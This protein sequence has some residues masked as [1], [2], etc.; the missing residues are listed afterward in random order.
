MSRLNR[1]LKECYRF[2]GAIPTSFSRAFPDPLPPTGIP[3]P[4]TSRSA[5][6]AA[7]KRTCATTP[8]AMR[9]V[10]AVSTP[11]PTPTR[12]GEHGAERNSSP[13]GNGVKPDECDRR[14]ADRDRGRGA[15]RQQRPRGAREQRLEGALHGAAEEQLLD[16]RREEH[17]G[18]DRDGELIGIRVAERGQQAPPGRGDDL[19]DGARDERD[20]NA[21]HE[22]DEGDTAPARGP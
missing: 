3:R 10:A 15:A 12:S 6:P 20:E 16:D 7:L 22:V 14:D 5:M 19:H 18:D 21:E 11:A 1:G 4:H 13:V 2:V 9:P 8:A 17:D